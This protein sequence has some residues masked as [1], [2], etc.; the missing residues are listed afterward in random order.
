MTMVNSF[1]YTDCSFVQ[2]IR[3]LSLT[4]L[5]NSVLHV[6]YGIKMMQNIWTTNLVLCHP[7]NNINCCEIQGGKTTEYTG[8]VVAG[9]TYCCRVKG[10]GLGSLF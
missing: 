4:A 1:C 7:E 3:C 9:I 2:C 10:S 5:Q 8:M 6:T